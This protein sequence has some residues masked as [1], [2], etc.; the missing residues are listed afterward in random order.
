MLSR[1]WATIGFDCSPDTSASTSV[2]SIDLNAK[3]YQNDA[4]LT[5]R[6]NQYVAEVREFEGAKWAGKN[7]R[8]TDIDGRA[9]QV[10][11]PKGSLAEDKQIVIDRVRA[12]AVKDTKRPV[13]IIVTEH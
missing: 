4:S 13:D 10:I 12:R 9:V 3:N 7:I 1:T 2:K 5:Y 6:L 8:E 11:V